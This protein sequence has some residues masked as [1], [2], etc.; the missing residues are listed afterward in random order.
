M[1]QHMRTGLFATLILFALENIAAGQQPPPPPP[2][3]PEGAGA[4]P[5][6][7]AQMPMPAMAVPPGT[8]ANVCVEN[9]VY[10]PLGPNSYGTVFEKVLDVVSEYFEIAFCN[11]YDGRIESYPRIA[12]GLEQPWRPGS[13]DWYGRLLATFQ[14]IRHRCFV[15]IQVADDGG[16][17]VQVVVFRELEDLPRPTRATAGAAAFRGDNTIERQFEVIDPAF[18]DSHWAPI[19]RDQCL[20]KAIIDKIKKC[21]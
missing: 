6:A 13:P 15:L 20:E 2:P 10:V 16:Y 8:E 1:R 21:L 19:G 11:R 14:S 17:F 12:P 5:P 18:F 3:P 4:A 7:P 9:P